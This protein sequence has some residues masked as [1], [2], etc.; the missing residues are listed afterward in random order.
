MIL[1]LPQ[2]GFCWMMVSV[3]WTFDFCLFPADSG[4]FGRKSMVSIV[5]IH[6]TMTFRPT[7]EQSE[8]MMLFAKRKGK[9][10][11]LAVR[12]GPIDSR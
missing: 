9:K 1:F 11:D 7:P 5:K 4:S 6:Y 10:I 3:L 8:M 12:K 2:K